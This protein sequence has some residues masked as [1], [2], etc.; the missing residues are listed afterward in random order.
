MYAFFLCS[1]CAHSSVSKVYIGVGMVVSFISVILWV[2]ATLVVGI[3][4]STVGYLTMQF[5]CVLRTRFRHFEN[6][7]NKQQKYVLNVWLTV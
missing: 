3:V 7:V 4:G 1:S 2:S 6:M 5:I